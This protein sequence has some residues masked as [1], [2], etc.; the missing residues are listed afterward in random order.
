MYPKVDTI[1]KVWK[2]TE[3]FTL[4][5]LKEERVGFYPGSAFGDNGFGHFRTVMLNDLETPEEV[6]NRL[7]SF[8]K[9]HLKAV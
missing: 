3:E 5:L 4:E 1:G 7:E 8:R 6:F 2:T 9:R